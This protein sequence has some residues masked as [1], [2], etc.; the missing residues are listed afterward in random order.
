RGFRG[1]RRLSVRS[2]GGRRAVRLCTDAQCEQRT[3]T[4]D[5]PRDQLDRLEGRVDLGNGVVGAAAPKC[6]FGHGLSHLRDE[7]ALRAPNGEWVNGVDVA[8]RRLGVPLEGV[9][10]RKPGLAHHA[11]NTVRAV[12][13]RVLGEFASPGPVAQT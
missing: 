12:S 3:K 9:E 10:M 8:L 6:Q 5:V 2:A 1:C 7:L 4:G 11:R 13:P